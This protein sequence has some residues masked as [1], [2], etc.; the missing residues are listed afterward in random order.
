MPT[1][2]PPE[3]VRPTLAELASMSEEA[4]QSAFDSLIVAV[5]SDSDAETAA[6]LEPGSS[7]IVSR[8]LAS[9]LSLEMGRLRWG[10]TRPKFVS[11]ILAYMTRPSGLTLD[12]EKRQVFSER[13]ETIMSVPAIAYKAKTSFV[14]IEH[15]HIVQDVRI[16]TDLRPVFPQDDDVAVPP[17][18]FIITH[19]LKI[20]YTD[21]DGHL[22]TLFATMDDGDVQKLSDQCTRALKKAGSLESLGSK[23][24]ARMVR[25]N[26][27]NPPKNSK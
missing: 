3:A 6:D 20:E 12:V 19:A 25:L 2:T 13:L 16:F 11:G 5:R 10:T 17:E 23:L 14:A 7:D 1:I 26:A 8:I 9:A 18:A 21:I 4:F 22:K 15:E 24:N 27:I